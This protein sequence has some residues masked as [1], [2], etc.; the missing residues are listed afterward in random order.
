MNSLGDERAQSHLDICGTR[1]LLSQ[2]V[3]VPCVP[4]IIQANISYVFSESYTG[5]H[6]CRN[7]RKC[8]GGKVHYTRWMDAWR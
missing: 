4:L 3:L 7:S 5:F 2:L 8:R 6:R 1:L